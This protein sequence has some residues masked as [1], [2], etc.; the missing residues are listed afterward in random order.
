M[1]K[2]T[3][4]KI[5]CWAIVKDK[6]TLWERMGE[7]FYKTRKEVHEELRWKTSESWTPVQI[8]IEIKDGQP[9]LPER[10]E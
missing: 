10:G 9:P 1:M 3:R 7:N 6:G 5:E 4:N 2:S 8:R